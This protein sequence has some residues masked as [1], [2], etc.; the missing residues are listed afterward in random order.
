MKKENNTILLLMVFICVTIVMFQ[1]CDLNK[2]YNFYFHKKY[3]LTE[4]ELK[5]I[6]RQEQLNNNPNNFGTNASGVDYQN[7]YNSY[8]QKDYQNAIKYGEQ[9]AQEE[10]SDIHFL[11]QMGYSYGELKL[12]DKALSYYKKAL[13]IDPNN[14]YSKDGYNYIKYYSDKNEQTYAMNNRRSSVH[15]PAKLYSLVKTD[16]NDNVKQQVYN[17][18]DILWQEVNARIILQT[19]MDRNIPIYINA[20]GT[21]GETSLHREGYNEIVDK[22]DVPVKYINDLNNTNLHPYSRI[23]NFNVFM[24]EF[25]HAFSRLKNPRTTDSLEEELGVSMIGYN[26]GYKMIYRRYMTDE[27]VRQ[28]SMGTLQALLSDD[29]SQLPVYSGF[30]RRMK[31]YAVY[32]PNSALYTDLV[33][34]YKQLL[35]QGK[36]KHVPNLDKLVKQ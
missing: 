5:Y 24:H 11:N 36:T 9:I 16:L 4:E 31:S 35:A 7:F 1:T 27:E 19:V 20:N 21:R 30:N 25:G 18:F 13:T 17:I 23:Y 22:I 29:H 28:R 34:M 3:Q 12:Y 2:V 15:A 6:P 14:P 26:I 33:G 32:M 10:S 8:M